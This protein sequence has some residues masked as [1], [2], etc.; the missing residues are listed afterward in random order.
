MWFYV[1]W[2]NCFKLRKQQESIQIY[3]AVTFI[4]KQVY[5][6]STL[7]CRF[8][9]RTMRSSQ[10]FWF[11]I[12]T[13]KLVGYNAGIKFVVIT[14]PI[15]TNKLIYFR[16]YK[17]NYSVYHINDTR[18]MILKRRRACD[19]SKIYLPLSLVLTVLNLIRHHNN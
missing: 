8:Q 2:K 14:S 9:I 15:K 18:Y 4:Y 13:F 17:F 16:L 6:T 11:I 1:N 10:G 7:V 3:G 19:S 12:H 5:V